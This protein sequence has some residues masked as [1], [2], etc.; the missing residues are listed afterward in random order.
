MPVDGHLFC[1]GHH[2]PSASGTVA[3][4][5]SCG[6]LAVLYRDAHNAVQIPISDMIRNSERPRPHVFTNSHPRRRTAD[7]PRLHTNTCSVRS[8]IGGVWFCFLSKIKQNNPTTTRSARRDRN[9]D[10]KV[11]AS[12]RAVP[13][14][15][16]ELYN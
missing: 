10:R 13:G 2:H 8:Q 16:Q 4:M 11:W 15:H 14:I 3:I 1:S 12:A 9:E 6:P 5:V 7:A